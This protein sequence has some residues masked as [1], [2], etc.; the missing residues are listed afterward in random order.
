MTGHLRLIGQDRLLLEAAMFGSTVTGIGLTEDILT[1][2]VFGQDKEDTGFGMAANGNVVE[3]DGI[4]EKAGGTGKIP[5]N[6]FTQVHPVN[7]NLVI[8]V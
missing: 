2:K 3:M 8:A 6:F 5:K 7:Y 4:G 1:A